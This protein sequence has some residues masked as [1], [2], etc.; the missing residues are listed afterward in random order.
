MAA[1]ELDGGLALQAVQIVDPRLLGVVVTDDQV[2]TV[3]GEGDLGGRGGGLEGGDL[4]IVGAVEDQHLVAILGHDVEAIA[5]RVGQQVGQV[6]GDVDESTALIGIAIV[7]EQADLRRD[8]DGRDGIYVYGHRDG[9][10]LVLENR[11]IDTH[12]HHGRSNSGRGRKGD[13]L[14]I[15]GECE[16]GIAAAG[17][18]DRDGLA[19][20]VFVA[21]GA[22][23]HHV[24]H[25]GGEAVLLVQSAHGEDHDA[26]VGDGV[27]LVGGGVE[28]A[29]AGNIFRNREALA[30]Q[31]VFGI[32]DGQDRRRGWGRRR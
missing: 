28:Q 8:V 10:V 11:G 26:A 16:I 13:P 7:D 29:A 31:Q 3:E 9:A 14:G 24:A 15:G 20:H 12:L 30:H 21:E 23:R 17:I 6:S 32:H 18:G 25:G 4:A 2:F 5:D 27:H 19:N 22:A 1:G